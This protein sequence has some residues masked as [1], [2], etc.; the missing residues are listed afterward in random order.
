MRLRPDRLQ[1]GGG[2][3]GQVA[4]LDQPGPEQ[5][6]VV[7]G[8]LGIGG[9]QVDQVDRVREVALVIGLGRRNHRGGDEIVVGRRRLHEEARPHQLAHQWLEDDVDGEILLEVVLAA[10]D[11]LDR[12]ARGLPD[13]IFHPGLLAQRVVPAGDIHADLGQV[14]RDVLRQPHLVGRIGQRGVVD[15]LRIAVTLR[16]HERG[17]KAK[18]GM[19]PGAQMLLQD[20]QPRLVEGYRRPGAAGVLDDV[21]HHRLDLGLALV[22]GAFPFLVGRTEGVPVAR[23]RL[24]VALLVGPAALA[25]L[26]L[27]DPV[28][29]QVALGIGLD[30]DGDVLVMGRPLAARFEVIVL[31]AG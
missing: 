5:R 25:A 15:H 4:V 8:V 30:V 6:L 23:Q 2:L 11:R 21:L 14:Q 9:Q 10:H 19:L 27:D 13:R 16:L 20:R 24:G 26:E 31:A 22:M 28:L 29:D 12:L 1:R 3:V 17:A 18:L 7:I